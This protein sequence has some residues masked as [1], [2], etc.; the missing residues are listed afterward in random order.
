MSAVLFP[1][2][3]PC[4]TPGYEVV[5]KDDFPVDSC[6]AG[7]ETEESAE[8]ESAVDIDG[9]TSE[10]GTDVPFT[11]ACCCSVA[12]SESRLPTVVKEDACV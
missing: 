7:V 9:V 3:W 4:G 6:L 11:G 5:F 8:R 10:R 2:R 12:I 1:G